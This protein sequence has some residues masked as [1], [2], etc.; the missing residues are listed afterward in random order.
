MAA[1]SIHEISRRQQILAA[2]VEVF[3]DKGY[4][5]ARVEEIA[6]RAGIGKGTVYQYFRT[7]KDLFQEVVRE[8]MDYYRREIQREQTSTEPLSERVLR[9]AT[10]Q[11]SFA[12]R[13]RTMAKVL[14]NSPETISQ[15]AKDMYMTVRAGIHAQ[16][17]QL[18]REAAEQ[19][20]IS[21][22]DYDTAAWMMLGALNAIATTAIL[23][24]KDLDAEV[25]ARSFTDL[26]FQGLECSADSA[27]MPMD[28]QD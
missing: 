14:M 11:L 19:G 22:I 28:A 4:H 12:V 20:E 18:F 26:F 15:A 25:L 23:T 8:G 16:L 1:K 17:A 6:H 5:A 7:K 2:A 21:S 13:H 27:A 24:E 9:I 10:M 3:S